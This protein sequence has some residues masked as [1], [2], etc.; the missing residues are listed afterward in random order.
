M[1]AS[2]TSLALEFMLSDVDENLCERTATVQAV[3][4][5]AGSKL[6]LNV[7]RSLQ[8]PHDGHHGLV[9]TGISQKE[10]LPGCHLDAVGPGGSACLDQF[11]L[12]LDGGETEAWA[13]H[14]EEVL[15]TRRRYLHVV[16]QR[17]VVEG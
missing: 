15:V 5:D 6:Q 14:G 9:E 12:K 17:E 4:V 1:P 7:L 13:P 2:E 16:R 8:R 3:V 10:V 11:E